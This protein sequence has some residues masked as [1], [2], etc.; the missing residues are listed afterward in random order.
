[1]SSGVAPD[2]S[3]VDIYRALPPGGTPALID[4]ALRPRS[5]ILELGSGPGRLTHPLIGLGHRVVAVD[6]SEEMLGHVR[7]GD[8]ILA[9]VFDLDLGRAFD[10]VIAASHFIN[11]PEPERR[12]RLLRVCHRHLRPDGVALVER[13]PPEWAA[14]PR[15]SE[16]AVGP[17]QVEFE[18]LETEDGWF[19][20]R[21]TYT[22]DDRVWAQEFSAAAVTDEMLA[23]E[24][25]ETGLVLDGWI[26]EARTW[27]RLSPAG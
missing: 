17:V 11:D 26:D 22:L 24:A 27:A 15:P 8:T 20:G 21:V 4:T 3:P 9:D 10:A 16:S 2:G 6:D 13:Y 23:E 1:M 5:S 12:R 25:A 18:P 14:S 19:R 7:G